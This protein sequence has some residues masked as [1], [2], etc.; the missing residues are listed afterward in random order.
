MREFNKVIYQNSH[1]LHNCYSNLKKIKY[2]YVFLSNTALKKKNDI[3]LYHK[4]SLFELLVVSPSFQIL[5]ILRQASFVIFVTHMSLI[6]RCCWCKLLPVVNCVH[7][8][9][10]FLA[11][12]GVLRF[13][14]PLHYVSIGC[15][16][17]TLNI[18][19]CLNESI[20]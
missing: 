5:L 10:S 6:S 4:S 2:I 7:Y 11:V 18:R 1:L 3:N 8:Y 19:C 14:S 13:K 17:S 16:F 20:I 12:V 9:L 15:H